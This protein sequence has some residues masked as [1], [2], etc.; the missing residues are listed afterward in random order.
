MLKQQLK[1]NQKNNT[2]MKLKNQ[3]LLGVFIT[4]LLCTLS[5]GKP[6]TV[7][8]KKA[9]KEYVK[10]LK[11]DAQ[12]TDSQTLVIEEYA[13]EYF[14]AI[15]SANSVADKKA[16][17]TLKKQAFESFKMQRDSLLK[18]EQKESLK[19][20]VEQRKQNALNRNNK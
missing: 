3:L 8:A 7:T 16:K 9:A 12:L 5:A 6:V 13:A 11:T 1:N 18:P 14:T 19:T 2:I 4:I 20:S 17:F 15:V 10:R